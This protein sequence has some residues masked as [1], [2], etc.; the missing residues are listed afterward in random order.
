MSK[1]TTVRRLAQALTI[2]LAIQSSTCWAVDDSAKKM[3]KF[4]ANSAEKVCGPKHI[5]ATIMKN[6]S[7]NPEVKKVADF[8]AKKRSVIL[9]KT[10]EHFQHN[11]ET[12]FPNIN[13]NNDHLSIAIITRILF[14]SHLNTLVSSSADNDVAFKDYLDGEIADLNRTLNPKKTYFDYGDYLQWQKMRVDKVGKL[15][16]TDIEWLTEYITLIRN[17]ESQGDSIAHELANKTFL[18]SLINACV[19]YEDVCVRL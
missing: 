17:E 9:W 1:E 10:L 6:W 13:T 2:V 12:I 3:S 19:Q 5:G 18:F 4:L 7:D 15:F 8:G 11:E 14:L 16:Y